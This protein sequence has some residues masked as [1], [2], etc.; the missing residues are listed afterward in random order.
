MGRPR[1]RFLAFLTFQ[2]LYVPVAGA[3]IWAGQAGVRGVVID[4]D[5]QFLFNDQVQL[6][7]ALLEHGLVRESGT[8]DIHAM[9][10]RAEDIDT[11][12]E[13]QTYGC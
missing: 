7:H 4:L 9:I 12:Q 8:N 3:Q 1:R 10:P 13:E 2:I 11:E 6:D 5:G